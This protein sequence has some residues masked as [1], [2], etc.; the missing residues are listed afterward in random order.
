MWRLLS[1]IALIST[2]SVLSGCAMCCA[3]FD[4]A[5]PTYGGKWERVDR[6]HGRVGSAFYDAGAGGEVVETG[7]VVE[8]LQPEPDS[9][10]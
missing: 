5:Y 2:T 8:E 3:P 1:L 7:E 6:F 4:D 9:G 10:N